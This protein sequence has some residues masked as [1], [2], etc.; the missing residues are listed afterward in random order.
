MLCIVVGG[1]GVAGELMVLPSILASIWCHAPWIEQRIW[2]WV[3]QHGYSACVCEN[4][5]IVTTHNSWIRI[6]GAASAAYNDIAR[7][8]VTV[9]CADVTW[10]HSDWRMAADG[11]LSPGRVAAVINWF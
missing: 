3:W 9:Q 4:G 10:G 5:I 8:Q 11:V 1:R 6:D 7:I 2:V